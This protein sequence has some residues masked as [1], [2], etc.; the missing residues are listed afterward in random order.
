MRLSVHCSPHIAIKVIVEDHLKAMGLEYDL[1]NANDL[2]IKGQVDPEHYEKLT[3]ELARYG[4][5]LAEDA[6]NDLIEQIKRAVIEMVNRGE[7]HPTVNISDYL[8]KKLNYSYGYITAV[9]SEATYT[10]I[11]HFT[12]LQKVERIKEMLLLDKLTLTEISYRLN[13][14]S[15]AYLSN[16]FKMITGL[17]PTRF[18]E[19][20]L[21]KRETVI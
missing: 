3:S 10:S 2:T 18:K 16:Q 1:P 19:I 17:T 21:K 14:S 8:S 6:P 9:F 13:Y 4:I 5:E 7:D 12:I 20:M 15:V 11:A